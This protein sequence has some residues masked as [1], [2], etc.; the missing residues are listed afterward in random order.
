MDLIKFNA[1]IKRKNELLKQI[2]KKIIRLEARSDEVLKE[3]REMYKT[4]WEN[5][6]EYDEEKDEWRLK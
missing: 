1:D 4:A 5:G 6:L 2:N 3:E